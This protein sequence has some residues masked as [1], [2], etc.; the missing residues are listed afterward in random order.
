MPSSGDEA[1]EVDDPA[2]AV[3]L[4]GGGHGLR[5]VAILL[6][7]VALVHRVHQIDDGIHILGRGVEGLVIV[8][9]EVHRGDVSA[10]GEARFLARISHGSV[11]VVTLFEQ[12]R[13]QPRPDVSGCA[14]DQHSHDFLVSVDRGHTPS[15]QSHSPAS[16]ADDTLCG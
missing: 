8:E 11:H 2:Q 3:A 15:E 5:G 12:D 16:E 4:R 10:P 14:G 13:D 6:D 1:G 9:V 7:E